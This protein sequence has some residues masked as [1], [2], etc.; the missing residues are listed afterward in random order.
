[1]IALGSHQPNEDLAAKLQLYSQFV[2]SC[3]FDH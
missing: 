2:G 1:M 3:E